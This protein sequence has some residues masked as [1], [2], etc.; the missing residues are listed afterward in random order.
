[1]QSKRSRVARVECTKL[2]KRWRMPATCH[3]MSRRMWHSYCIRVARPAFLSGSFVSGQWPLCRHLP[4]RSKVLV[5]LVLTLVVLCVAVAIPI[6]VFG[7][8]VKLFG[9]G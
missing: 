7:L 5:V 8:L 2:L 4:V 9:H 1:M 6:G 3:S